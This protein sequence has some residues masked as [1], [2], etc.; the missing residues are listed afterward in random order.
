M[1]KN[2]ILVTLVIISASLGATKAYL[3]HQLQISLEKWRAS[4]I[5]SVTMTYQEIYISLGGAIIINH[6]NLINEVHIDQVILPKAYRVFYPSPFSLTIKGLQIPIS[7]TS[8]PVPALITILGYTPYYLTPRE[9]R[10]IG[11]IQLEANLELEAIPDISLKIDAQAWGKLELS[12]DLLPPL[13]KW[14]D[15]ARIEQLSLTHFKLS[16]HNQGLVEQLLSYLAKRQAVTLENLKA[17][18]TNQFT[19][20]IQVDHDSQTQLRQFIQTPTTLTLQWQPKP[21]LRL[22]ELWTASPKRLGL[23]I[24]H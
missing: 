4:T 14:Q 17:T 12:V 3:E 16:Y 18:L 2:F 9:L 15:F 8:P 24:T 21:S 10:Q 19:K 11:Y 1:K 5:P 20:D 23:T 6:L 13:A 7:D 22:N